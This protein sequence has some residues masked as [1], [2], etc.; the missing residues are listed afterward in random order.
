MYIVEIEIDKSKGKQRRRYILEIS[1]GWNT[2]LKK[3]KNLHIEKAEEGK[4]KLEEGNLLRGSRN[5]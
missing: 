3:L 4:K 5:R 2:K 1:K